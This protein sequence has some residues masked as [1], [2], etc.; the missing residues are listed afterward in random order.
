[1]LCLCGC[2]GSSRDAYLLNR[3]LIAAEK[4]V[5]SAGKDF[6]KELLPLKH[7]RPVGPQR[8]KKA[9]Q[10]VLD[11]IA[12]ARQQVKSLII[13]DSDSARALVK[14]FD[15]YLEGQEK[16]YKTD[17]DEVVGNVVLWK[18]PGPAHWTLVEVMVE[19]M[20]KADEKNLRSLRS[21][22]KTFAEEYHLP[23]SAGN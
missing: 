7:E 14:A 13:P 17:G 8:L 18:K 5:A 12:E 21:A 4:R 9:Y 1:M 10:H 23:L 2:G 19:K 15:N 11:T 6:V 3:T 20:E 16:L 22:Q